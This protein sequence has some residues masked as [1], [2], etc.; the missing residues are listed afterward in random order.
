M[1]GLHKMGTIT[2][3]STHD[4]RVPLIK[5]FVP[6]APVERISSSARGTSSRLRDAR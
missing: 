2:L 4:N 3:G 5:D 1:A 6:L